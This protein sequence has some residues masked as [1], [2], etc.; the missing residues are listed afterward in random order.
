M[1][2]QGELLLAVLPTDGSTEPKL[3]KYSDFTPRWYKWA[4]NDYLLMSVSFPARRF[5]FETTESRLATMDIATGKVRNLLKLRRPNPRADP[6][7]VS[8]RQDNLLST[9]PSD[10]EHVLIA[11]DMEYP[12][13]PGV[14]QVNVDGGRPGRVMR[15]RGAVQNWSA[16]ASGAVRLGW[17]FHQSPSGYYEDD[18]RMIFRE[19]PDDDFRVLAKYNT[20]D[21]SGEGFSFAGFTE[22]PY[23]ILIADRNEHGR[24]ALF[25]Y[26]TRQE[27]IVE[28][29]FSHERYDLLGLSYVTG[30]DRPRAAYYVADKLEYV[31]FDDEARKQHEDIQTAFPGMDGRLVSSSLD[32][33]K[34]IVGVGT[35]TTPETF[36]YFDLD[37]GAMVSLGVEYPEL[38]NMDF[39]EIRP[40]RYAAR[41]G[42]EIPGYLTVPKGIQAQNLPMIVFPHGGPAARD[43]KTYNYWVQYFVSRGWAVLQPNFRG[44]DGYGIAF[45]RAGR[46]EWGLTMQDDVTD[47]VQW[48]IDQG[49]ADPA[50]ICIVGGSYGAYAAVQGL[51]KTPDLYRCGV[52]L[53]GVYDIAEEISDG[54]G[55]TG[56]LQLRRFL[57]DENLSEVSPSENAEKVTAPVLIAYG[58]KDRV[59]EYDQSTI[60]ISALERADKDVTEVRL[61]DGDHSLT[62]QNNRLEFFKAM[63]AFLLTHLGLGTGA[64]AYTLPNDTET[65]HGAESAAAE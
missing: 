6:I 43:A 65:A 20:Q 54:W 53:N 9:L 28:T 44:S 58:T 50:R 42:L 55:Y 13:R 29:L 3:V 17:G 37:Q 10:P 39:A 2:G 40:I 30:T 21:P 19:N 51:V 59:V 36:Y 46:K 24:I 7:H 33:T 41:D 64:V 16:D 57:P 11:L 34:L 60:M 31:F 26:D 12:T 25:R 14:Y 27:K 38:E 5:G 63:D 18:V 15:H 4:G 8:Q 32:G 61:K 45:E 49:I 52:G 56:F 62:Q 47:G 48:A 35:P 1:N 23:E 22:K